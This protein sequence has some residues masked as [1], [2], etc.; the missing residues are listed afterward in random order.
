MKEYKITGKKQLNALSFIRYVAI[1]IVAIL[2]YYQYKGELDDFTITFFSLFFLISLVPVIFLHVEYLKRNSNY[3]LLIDTDNKYFKL[4]NAK[5]EKESIIKFSEIE[6]I[7]IYCAP[8]V[9]YKES[10]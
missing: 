1:F 8:S 9:K 5:E 2:A 4:Y 6:Q 7:V 3:K 10:L